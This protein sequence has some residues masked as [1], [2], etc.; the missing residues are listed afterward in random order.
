MT[1]RHQH[2]AAMAHQ[3][4]HASATARSERARQRA[5]ALAPIVAELRAA[6][7]TS[8]PRLAAG[9]TRAGIPA[10][11]GPVWSHVAVLRM[12]K[13]IPAPAAGA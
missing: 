3:A 7:A 5:A 6:G 9:L 10:P 13:L 12:L 8:L 1:H 11:R 2:L 4:G